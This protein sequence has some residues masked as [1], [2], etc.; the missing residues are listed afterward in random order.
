MPR[1]SK[2]FSITLS[3]T[4]A[5][6]AIESVDT[7]ESAIAAHVEQACRVAYERGRD[8]ALEE[9]QR[10]QAAREADRNKHVDAALRSVRE[11]VPQMLQQAETAV[12]EL[13]V[14]VAQKFVTTC[15]VTEERL[16]TLVK[17]AL[18]G[19]RDSLKIEVSLHPDDLKLLSSGRQDLADELQIAG[20]LVFKSAANLSR[21]GCW[22]ETDFGDLDATI[23]AKTKQIHNLLKGP[24]VAA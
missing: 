5:N 1:S 4:I 9:S 23:E 16:R 2:D 17:N 18:E 12:K 15:P 7:H 20:Q 8:I 3:P 21:G 24:S 10:H 19:M 22:V 14:R 13:A 11:A 6:A